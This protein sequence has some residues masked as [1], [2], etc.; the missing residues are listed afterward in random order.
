MLSINHSYKRWLLGN[1]LDKVEWHK[2]IGNLHNEDIIS[3]LNEYSDILLENKSSLPF[4][5]LEDA[6]IKEAD[7]IIKKFEQ[8]NILTTVKALK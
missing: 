5:Q 6:L 2:R 1:V 4:F 3:E 8:K 7:S